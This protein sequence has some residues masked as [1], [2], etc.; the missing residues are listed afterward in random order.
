[1]AE[2]HTI[3]S[4][5][6]RWADDDPDARF[7]VTDDDA[8]TYRD[9]DVA[10]ARVARTLTAAGVT[11]GTRVGLLMPNGIDW[12]VLAFATMRMGAVLVP[13]STLL[14]P[15][16]LHAQL[17]GAGIEHLLLAREFRGR[18]YAADLHTVAEGFPVGADD[19]A[20][21]ARVPRLRAVAFGADVVHAEDTEDAPM[22]PGFVAA[23]DASVRPADDM[24]V[25]F[26]SGSR[27]APKGV[28]H[29][30]GSALGAVAASLEPRCL[31]RGDRLYL[32]M[33]FFW[34]GGFGGGL[35]SAFVA[36]ATLVTEAQPEPARTLRLLER[37]RVTLFRGWP[38]QA[39]ALA[40]HPDFPSTDLSAL[41]PGSLDAVLPPAEQRPPGARANLFGMTESFGPY[42]ADRLDTD[43]PAGTWGSCGRP[44][45]P[46]EVRVVDIESGA[47][48]GA[49]VPTGEIGEIQLRGPNMMRGICGRL[50]ADVF[51]ADGF[52]PTGDLGTRD[53]DGY[54][55]FVGR[56]DDMVKVKGA[57]VYPSEVEAALHAVPG[58]RR[59]VVVDLPAG[60]TVE[61]GAAVVLD[62]GVTVTPDDLDR[63]A[64]TRL[65]A[66]KVPAR[67]AVIDADAVPTTPTGKVDKPRL[68]RLFEAGR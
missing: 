1:M 34:M 6:R 42:C 7:L 57:S 61:L 59:A 64:R 27:G 36:G 40:A 38:D 28:I 67:W 51:T 56:R 2:R 5:L 8:L 68:Q 44:I 19:R 31:E 32:P 65:S 54:L 26:T 48:S 62:A 13:L 55:F 35:L 52:Y 29:T 58:V 17:L 41:K 12:A 20:F 21:D 22:P 46:M 43:L 14:R 63:E 49:P 18:D 53:A 30:H 4:L 37:E 9:L 11:K 15:P 45:P 50:R 25:M 10:T 47:E 66:F 16:E 24:V 33:P 23:L 3:P 39:A 60:D